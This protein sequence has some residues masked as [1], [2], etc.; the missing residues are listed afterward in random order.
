MTSCS[1][2]VG[3]GSGKYGGSGS[4]ITVVVVDSARD[5]FRVS[6]RKRGSSLECSM[7]GETAGFDVL[8]ADTGGDGTLFFDAIAAKAA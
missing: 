1:G 5:D 6:I 7:S 2:L 3:K 8:L 4:S